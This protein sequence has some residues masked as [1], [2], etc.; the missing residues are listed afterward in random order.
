L[1][2]S[3]YGGLVNS[4]CGHIDILAVVYCESGSAEGI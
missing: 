4:G 2:T 3:M 1:F